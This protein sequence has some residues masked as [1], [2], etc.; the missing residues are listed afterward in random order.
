MVRKDA[1]AGV[2]LSEGVVCHKA[3]V[4]RLEDLVVPGQIAVL[5]VLGSPDEIVSHIKH[6]RRVIDQP[7]QAACTNI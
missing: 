1:E 5:E 2:R 3:S 6:G 7:S 4:L